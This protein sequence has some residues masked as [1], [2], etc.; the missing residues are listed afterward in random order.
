MA[1]VTNL[2]MEMATAAVE[3]AKVRVIKKA[4]TM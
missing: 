3:M 1:M 2:V 4:L